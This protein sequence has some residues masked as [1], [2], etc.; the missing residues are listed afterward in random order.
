MVY[1]MGN[2]TSNG[3]T[4]IQGALAQEAKPASVDVTGSLDIWYDSAIL[5]TT[6]GNGPYSTATGTWK[7]F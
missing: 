7:D 5:E 2:I 1:V 6:S 4:E 3:N